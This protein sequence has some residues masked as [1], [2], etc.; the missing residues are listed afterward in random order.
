MRRPRSRSRILPRMTA[1]TLG[2]V[3]TLL[4][5]PSAAV[6]TV[7]RE[8]GSPLTAP[9]WYRWMGDAFEVVI[10]EGDGKLLHL[11]RDPRC[12]LV[13]SRPCRRSV[14]ARC[15][16]SRPSSQVTS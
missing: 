10:A 6:L 2:D 11:A 16:G 13:T 7:T 3:R 4:E 1:L 5:A 14:A 12:T 9:V 8:D 15:L